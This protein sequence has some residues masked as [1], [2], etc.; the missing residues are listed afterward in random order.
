[1]TPANAKVRHPIVEERTRKLIE[2]GEYRLRQPG[3][4]GRP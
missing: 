3:G 4:M 2:Y 1:M